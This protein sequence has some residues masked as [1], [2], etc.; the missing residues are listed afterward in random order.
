MKGCIQRQGRGFGELRDIV[1]HL[2]Q[3]GRVIIA[4]DHFNNL[5]NCPVKFLGKSYNASL[6]PV[7]L[8][9]LAGVP[10]VAAIPVLRN[11]VI[12]IDFG[13]HFNLRN[14]NSRSNDVMQNLILFLETQLKNNP[15]C[16]PM[17]FYQALNLV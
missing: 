2:K 9:A 1:N 14:L 7:R 11:G 13:S 8:A 12:N 3:N 17:P 4:F 16:W 15:G 10:L 5:T 6:T